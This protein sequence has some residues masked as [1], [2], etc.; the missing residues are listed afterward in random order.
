LPATRIPRVLK[1]SAPSSFSGDHLSDRFQ[2]DA[3]A[4]AP[5]HQRILHRRRR[6]RQWRQCWRFGGGRWRRSLQ[7]RELESERLLEQIGT[8]VCGRLLGVCPGAQRTLP[9]RLCIGDQGWLERRA[10]LAS[11]I[12]DRP[13]DLLGDERARKRMGHEVA[14]CLFAVDRS[15]SRLQ[16]LTFRHAKLLVTLLDRVDYEHDELRRRWQACARFA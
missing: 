1:R 4:L 8:R 11:A 9:R 14:V 6:R 5:R 7:R 16:R 3:A 10:L 15:A 2:A 12:A 13:H